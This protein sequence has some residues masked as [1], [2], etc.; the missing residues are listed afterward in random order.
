MVAVPSALMAIVR[1]N[2]KNKNG[3]SLLGD[4]IMNF[5]RAIF[6]GE[7]A[8]TLLLS[9]FLRWTHVR[10]ASQ[11]LVLPDKTVLVKVNV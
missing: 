10:M 6:I 4:L 11:K 2:F 7:F 5:V 1:I 8:V 3:N 9:S